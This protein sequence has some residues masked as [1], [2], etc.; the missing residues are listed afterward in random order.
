MQHPEF[1]ELIS[2]YKIQ[3]TAYIK[4]DINVQNA[5]HSIYVI[6]VKELHFIRV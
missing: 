2:M 4:F 3:Y 6:G 1:M 5:I